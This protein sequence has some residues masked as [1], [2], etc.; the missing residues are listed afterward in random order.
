MTKTKDIVQKVYFEASPETIYEILMDSKKHAAIASSPAKMTKKIGGTFTA[1]DKYIFGINLDLE[2]GVR[3]VQA[4]RGKGWPK[5]HFSIVYYEFK[6]KGKGT[7]LTFTHV[8][9][10]AG[11]AKHLA[12]GWKSH[13]WEPLKK[14]FA[15]KK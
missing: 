7:D 10:P 12:S 8:G 14:M 4:W 13:Y 9:V 6:K 11:E 2:R 1:H 15:G 3:I 5:G